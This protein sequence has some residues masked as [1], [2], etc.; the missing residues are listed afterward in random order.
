MAFDRYKYV[1]KRSKF[2][3]ERE[4]VMRDILTESLIERSIF[5]FI[6]SLSSIRLCGD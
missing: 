6:Q 1:N 3:A 4:N 2:G 5:L